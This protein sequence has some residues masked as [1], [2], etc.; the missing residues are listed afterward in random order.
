MGFDVPE[1]YAIR[2]DQKMYYAFFVFPNRPWGLDQPPVLP[3]VKDEIWQGRL[4]LRGLDRST[5]YEAVDYEH[6]K[7]LG[8]VKG[9][10]PHLDAKFTNHLV[11]E[12]VPK[13]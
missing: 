11:L 4:E 9:S 1:G 8:R 3:P 5:E 10:D 13:S 7:S 12:V 2:K 6:G